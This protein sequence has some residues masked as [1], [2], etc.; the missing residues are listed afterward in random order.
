MVSGPLRKGRAWFTDALEGEYDLLIFT[1]L[2]QGAD[3][4][5]AWRASNLSKAQLNLAQN[6]NLTVS[7]LLNSLDAPHSGLDPLDPI[8]TTRRYSTNAYIFTAKDQHL[9]ESGLLLEAGVATSS[10][11][12]TVSPQGSQTYIE[13]PNGTL[14]NYYLT[15]HGRGGRTEVIGNLF[16]PPLYLAGRHE[17][18]MGVDFD[19][20]DNYQ[21][22]IR[23]PYLIERTDGT[24][25]RR[26]TFTNPL[27]FTRYD[28]E[29]SGYV[30][31]RWTFARRWLVEPGLRFDADSTVHGIAA[32]PRLASTVMLKHNGDSKISWGVGVYRDPSN[33]SLLT[34][35]LTG[36]RIDYF[37]DSTGMNLIL[38]PV[39]STFTVDPNQLRFSFATNAS[40]AFEQKLPRTTYLRIQ[41]MDRRGRNIWTFENPGGSYSPTG[42]FAGDFILTNDRHDHYDSAELTLRHIFPHNHVVFASY[43]RSRALTNADFGFNLD[44]VLFS[45][46][47]GGPLPWDTPNRFL[48]WGWL[49][50]THKF[51]LAYTLD[52]RS[53]FPF[54]V[55]NDSQEVVGSP[56]SRRFPPYFSLDLSLERRFTLLGY[57]WALRAGLDNVTDRGNYSYVNSNIDSPQFLTFSGAQGHSLVTRIRLLGRK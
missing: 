5:S 45:P 32:S 28:S 43:T 37:Y 34:T 49:P 46:Q 52:W 40:V 18:K 19:R 53:G 39:P 12:T 3:R 14:G 4:S 11:Y 36:T 33:L 8:S 22:F 24:V 55:Q 41:L 17:F 13:T 21:E 57:Q 16:V 1:E 6:N 26:V 15:N 35:S 29:N 44:N 51:D 7:L 54:T 42:P 10:F 47:S 38:P 2:P 23:E 56:G 9:F 25:S 31:D 27:P 20:L 30:Q 48:S 50:F